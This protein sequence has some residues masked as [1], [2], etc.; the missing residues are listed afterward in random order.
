MQ[1]G[2]SNSF[3]MTL[4]RYHFAKIDS[5]VGAVCIGPVDDDKRGVEAQ[6]GVADIIQRIAKP[7]AIVKDTVF[8]TPNC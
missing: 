4:G 1:R 5:G 8:P 6:L 7:R 2:V 3:R